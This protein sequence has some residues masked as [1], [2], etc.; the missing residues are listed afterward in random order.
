M[1]KKAELG[2]RVRNRVVDARYRKERLFME[3][4][5]RHRRTEN[6]F[7]FINYKG[8]NSASGS[9]GRNVLNNNL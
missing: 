7:R 2:R 6:E 9:V 5:S 3:E 4:R 1:A 8:D